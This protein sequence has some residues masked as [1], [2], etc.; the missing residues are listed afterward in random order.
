MFFKDFIYLFFREG[1]REE[2]RKGGREEGRK[3]PRKRNIRVWYA[4][5]TWITCLSHAP[6]WA[7]QACVL[8]GSGTGDL[9][10]CCRAMP[11]SPSHTSQCSENIFKE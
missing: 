7:T 10:F 9:L 1:G 5:E 8:T 3:G 11:P 4:R 2:G 6:K